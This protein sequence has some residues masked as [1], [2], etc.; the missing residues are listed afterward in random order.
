MILNFRF[1]PRLQ[2][3]CS[4]GKL[5]VGGTGLLDTSTSDTIGPNVDI[6]VTN[7]FVTKNAQA[8]T[9]PNGEFD[10][11]E[12]RFWITGGASTYIDINITKGLYVDG[13]GAAQSATPM[14]WRLGDASVGMY[15]CI[16]NTAQTAWVL[17]AGAPSV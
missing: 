1:D 14:T 12:L 6:N 7:H 17:S 2:L 11:Q 10:G 15:S 4:S 9:L 13:T 5:L 16:W 3:S 8:I